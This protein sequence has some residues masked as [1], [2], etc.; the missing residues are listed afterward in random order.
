L[1]GYGLGGAGKF[2]ERSFVTLNPDKARELEI[3][4]IPFVRKLLGEFSDRPDTQKY[5]DRVEEVERA[6][7]QQQL[8]LEE[9]RVDER[10]KH[11]ESKID[12]LR[13]RP[14]IQ[15]SQ[16]RLR[17]LRKYRDGIEKRIEADPESLLQHMEELER[18]RDEID[19]QINTANK[20]I[21]DKLGAE[22]DS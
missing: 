10:G 12:L 21:D 13:L 6:F 1:F 5:Y 18:I 3:N 22:E 11:L 14:Y 7:K 9:G 8:L 4:D 2:A 17:A 16:K 20:F 19:S 15:L